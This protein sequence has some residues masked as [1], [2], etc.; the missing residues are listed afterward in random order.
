MPQDTQDLVQLNPDSVK[1]I[2]KLYGFEDEKKLEEAIDILDAWIKKQNHFTKKDFPRKYLESTILANKGSIERSKSKLDKLCTLRAILG[3]F[4]K[5][6]N[7]RTDFS[8]FFKATTLIPLPKLTDKHYR[9]ILLRNQNNEYFDK[10]P[11]TDYYKFMLIYCEYLLMHDYSDG[12]MFLIDYTDTN[13]MKVMNQLNITEFKQFSTLI[14]EG[15][16]TRIKG[17]HIITT[18]KT[19]EML[20]NIVKPVFSQKIANR[21]SVHSSLDTLQEIIPK[22]VLPVEYGGTER[23]YKEIKDSWIE[24]LSSKESMEYLKAS[25]EATVNE[26]YRLKSDYNEHLGLAGTFRTLSID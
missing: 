2:R 21:F 11:F 12:M 25:R 7:I 18:S 14:T 10:T 22:N 6:S 8:N 16:G 19:I 20:L 23:S 17:V 15:Y 9:V 3:F 1:Y 4:F 13:V 24:L 26:A 5:F